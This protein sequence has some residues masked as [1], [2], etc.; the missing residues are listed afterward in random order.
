MQ[1]DNGSQDI[2]VKLGNPKLHSFDKVNFFVTGFGSFGSI[3]DNPTSRLVEVIQIENEPRASIL[4]R[5]KIQVSAEACKQYV[6]EVNE[7]YQQMKVKES[8]SLF[9]VISFGVNAG[10]DRINLEQMCYNNAD[11]CI[12]DVLNFQPKRQRICQEME[13]MEPLKCRIDLQAIQGN[14]SNGIQTH[15]IINNDPGT[16]ICNYMYFSCSWKL[17]NPNLAT[18]FI[19]VPLFSVISADQQTKCIN[20]ILGRIAKFYLAPP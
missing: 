15:V 10:A 12:P 13:I 9:V 7:L 6:S 1:T 5:K 11:F 3:D 8:N 16:Y 2:P 20:E 4:S 19:H 17:S 18:L 14:L